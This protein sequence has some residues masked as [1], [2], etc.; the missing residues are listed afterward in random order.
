MTRTLA[1]KLTVSTA[2]NLVLYAVLLFAPAGTWHW[3]RAWTFLGI[4]LLGTVATLRFLLPASEGLLNERL[5]FPFPQGQPLADKMVGLLLITEIFALI[6]F[7]PLDVF[8][9]HLLSKPGVVAS[10][11]GLAMFGVGWAIITLACKENP[12]AAAAV[13]LQEERQHRVI[14]TGVYRV[15]RHPMYSGAVLLFVGIA[16]W[17]ESYAA[18]LLMFFLIAT[19]ALR[20]FIEERFLK[21]KLDGYEAYI[22]R[23]RYRLV[24]YLW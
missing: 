7:I 20:I 18:A 12:F 17:L 6:A 9:F 14:D 10:C 22:K 19:L 24:P 16:L 11:G 21:Q 1:I 15:V 5:K 13:R 3:W 23:V 4:V 8:R 2:L